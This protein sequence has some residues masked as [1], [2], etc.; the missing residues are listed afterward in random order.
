MSA[1]AKKL[2]KKQER[3]ILFDKYNGKCA[4]CGCDLPDRWHADHIDPVIRDI[5]YVK[6]KGYTTGKDMLKPELDVLENKNPA[7]PKCNIMKHSSDIEG[8]RCMILA[9]VKS[10]NEYSNQYKFAKKFG[11]ISENEQRVEFYFERLANQANNSNEQALILP[12][13]IVSVCGDTTIECS[14]RKGDDCYNINDCS[15][16]IEQTEL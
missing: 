12:D 6:G 8:F 13:V 4:Y 3:K 16:K 14:C 2:T 5:V 15:L 11:L 9:F 10:L 7:C 1:K